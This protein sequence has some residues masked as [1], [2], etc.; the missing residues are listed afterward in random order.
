MS[1]SSADASLNMGSVVVICGVN[2]IAGRCRCLGQNTGLFVVESVT[3]EVDRSKLSREVPTL[4]R[5]ETRAL[6]VGGWP[7]RP[8]G[9]YG[10]V[11]E[12]A[13]SGTRPGTLVKCLPR[14]SSNRPHGWTSNNGGTSS[15]CGPLVLALKL[16]P[17]ARAR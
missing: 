12:M 2:D 1:R 10:F 3:A 5:P 9:D 11:K 4:D 8:V 14:A 7:A 13:Q 17:D 15:S 6:W 16:S